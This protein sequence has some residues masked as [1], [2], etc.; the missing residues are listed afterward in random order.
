MATESMP[1]GAAP[2]TRPAPAS[3][4]SA[5]PLRLVPGLGLVLA[6][7]VVA[8]LLGRLVPVIGGPVFGIVIGMVVGALR[9]PAARFRPG[10]AYA[11]KQ[12]LQIAIVLLGTGL[13]L[14]Q[15]LHTGGSSLPVM[16]G[17]MAAALLGAWLFGR[18]LGVSADL[19][20]LIG[21]GTGICGASAIAATSSVVGAGEMDIAYSISTIFLFNVIAVL[22]YPTIGH[23]LHFSQSAFGLWAGT[24]INDTSSVVAA[25]YTFGHAAGNHAVIVKLTR[26]TLIIPITLVLAAVRILRMRAEARRLHEAGAGDAKAPRISWRKLIPWFIL[27]FLVA[28]V[29]NTL[30]IFSKGATHALADVALFMIVMALAG[31]GLS[32]DFGQMRRTG[33]RPLV[34]GA[35]LWATVG[36]SSIAL[37]YLTG[38]L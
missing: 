15:I 34:L 23:L 4:A 8:Y 6:I 30:G 9:R 36:L 38:S 21:V 16:L 26:T 20:T 11:G 17:T 19:R 31:I 7:S 24:A 33:V 13:S 37:Q 2:A 28:A 22:T 35:I 18:L 25:A 5:G 32:A 1:Q 27:W 29:L 10:I 12:V 14:S 3:P